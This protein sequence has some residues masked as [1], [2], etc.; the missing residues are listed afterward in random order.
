MKRLILASILCLAFAAM[1][2]AQETFSVDSQVF[3]LKSAAPSVWGVVQNLQDSHKHQLA[4]TGV[5]SVQLT[6]AHLDVNDPG[7]AA[8]LGNSA[9]AIPHAN[10]PAPACQ[11]QAGL[12]TEAMMLEGPFLQMPAQLPAPVRPAI[13]DPR[14]MKL[15][16]TRKALTIMG[17][18]STGGVCS[19]PL[20][21]A[22]ADAVD[23]GIATVPAD[24]A[25]PIPL[26]R[27][28]APPCK[29]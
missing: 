13:L 14:A 5:C 27:V 12:M 28:P 1:L 16:L 29:K 22:H 15:D 2:R 6:E 10:V 26:A 9:V 7:I 11:S 24:S 4:N 17:S 18:P 25:V 20:I 8:T 21:E 19:V 23:P 3:P